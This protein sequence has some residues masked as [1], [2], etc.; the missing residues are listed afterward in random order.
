MNTGIVDAHLE[1]APVNVVDA[2][3][4]YDNGG[5]E[6]QRTKDEAERVSLKLTE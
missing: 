4:E 6:L 3:S 2:W 1:P 5:G